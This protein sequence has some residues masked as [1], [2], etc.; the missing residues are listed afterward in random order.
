LVSMHQLNKSE[1][2]F[3]FKFSNVPRIS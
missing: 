1:I 3:T 2:F